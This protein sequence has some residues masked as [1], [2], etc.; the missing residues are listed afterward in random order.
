MIIF[1]KKINLITKST[2]FIERCIIPNWTNSLSRSLYLVESCCFS[3]YRCLN[4]STIYCNHVSVCSYI[5][6]GFRYTICSEIK[7]KIDTEK[8]IKDI[9][10]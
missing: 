7:Q 5:F 2:I 9:L 1:V 6:V 4:C 10:E 8:D 3:H